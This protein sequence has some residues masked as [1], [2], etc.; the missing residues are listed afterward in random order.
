L[1][2]GVALALGAT[3]AF[4]QPGKKKPAETAKAADP[5][6][7]K[8]RVHFQNGVKLFQDGNFPG[9]LAEF[10]A[11]YRLKPGPGALKNIALCQKALFRYG[12]AVDTLK[13][14]LSQHEKELSPDDKNAIDSTIAELTSLVG[15][16][17]IKITPPDA[18]VFV[19][20]RY[21]DPKERAAGIQLN[22]GEHTLTA[23]AAGYAKISKSIRVAGG[24]KNVP[25]EL[26]LTAVAGFVHIK[27]K[28]PQAAIAIDQK[29]LSFGEWNGAVNAG[30]HYFQVYKQGY[31]PYERA[32]VVEVGRSQTIQ[33]PALTPADDDTPTPQPGFAEVKPRQV[34]GFYGMLVLSG[35]S[36]RGSPE[37]LKVDE[38]NASGAAVGARAGYRIW[39]P[40]ALELMLESARHDQVEACDELAPDNCDDPNPVTR[41]FSLE[42]LRIG[43]NL[44]IMSAGEKLRFT[45]T[46]GVGAV[47]HE[48]ELENSEPEGNSPFHKGKANGWDPYFLLE[49]GAQYNWGHILIELSAQLY[50]DGASNVSGEVG[51]G[52]AW[53]PYEDTGGLLI[54]GI[55]LRG[56]WSEWA[57]YDPKKR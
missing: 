32:F 16:I 18:R 33:V 21:V 47:R 4:A 42:A 8:A 45:S 31:E 25:V 40:I 34:R 51:D 50:V 1:V 52:E 22:T 13:R 54:G 20:G 14:V 41:K 29:P 38:A 17:V 23:D 10:E 46:A 35:Q 6:T 9:A 30:R 19:D 44:R 2:F 28:D 11:S 26:A 48:I 55:S 24:Q 12:E 5:Q 43:P 36:L 27:T 37:S 57:P 56:G 15:S 49:L 39:T 7:E 3:S 53:H